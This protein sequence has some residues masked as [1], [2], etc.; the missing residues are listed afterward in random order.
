MA[1]SFELDQRDL[2]IKNQYVYGYFSNIFRNSYR[3]VHISQWLL[4]T[5]T[6][7]EI[8][9][10]NKIRIWHNIL[11]FITFKFWQKLL[12]E[13]T[14][15]YWFINFYQLGVFS[16]YFTIIFKHGCC[17]WWQVIKGQTRQTMSDYKWL[18]VTNG[19]ITSDYEWLQKSKGNYEPEHSQYRRHYEPE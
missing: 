11:K 5:Y 14:S 16:F 13:A 8:F 19:Q 18:K 9:D 2:K 17:W 3:K 4:S 7:R 12:I 1:W 6:W 10:F 15:I